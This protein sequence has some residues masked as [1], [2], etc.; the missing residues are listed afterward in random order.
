MSKLKM[1]FDIYCIETAFRL[2]QIG[3]ACLMIAGAVFIAHF[4]QSI[5]NQSAG[6]AFWFL[7]AIAIFALEIIVQP[8]NS[9]F[10]SK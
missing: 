9:L 1:K 8:H 7:S 5:E 3:I 4:T 2:R 10:Q 6:I